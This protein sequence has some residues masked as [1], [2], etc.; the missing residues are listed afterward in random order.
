MPTFRYDC[1]LTRQQDSNEAPSFCIFHAPVGEILEW[2]DIKRLEEE[3]GAPQRR[4]SP[5]KVK[6]VTRYLATDV[7]NT[8]PTSVIL[9]LDVSAPAPILV[10]DRRTSYGALEFTHN[11]GEPRPGLVIDGQH[12]LLG[13][14]DF[15]PTFQ[16][17]V[18]A[19]FGANDMEKAF[20]FLVINNKASKVSMDHIR[21]LALHYQEDELQARLTTARLTLNPNLGF[22]GLV[23]SEEESPFRGMIDW[24]I[25]PE[26]NRVVVPAAIENAITY[27]QQQR[28]KEFESDDVLL[29]F[30]YTLWRKLRESWP[31]LWTANSHL[32]EKVG[33]LCMTQYLTDL[34][35][36]SYDLGKLDV[37]DP[38]AVGAVVSD[39]LGSSERHFW[40]KRWTSTSY[41]TKAGHEL[42]KRA[43]IQ[44]SR[45]V[46]MGL[47]WYEDVD[48]VDPG[49]DL[50]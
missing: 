25:T 5:A 14:N 48:L 29:E 6:A 46:R 47:A 15:D 34:L 16:V 28:V 36:N 26:P 17:N 50:V 4:M 27:I 20:Q 45:N 35:V 1:L 23:N 37:S 22:V 12:R 32:L 42:I 9:T 39:I 18:V 21:A 2:A 19:I 8:I 7:R 44:I 30:F 43:L 24:P 41:D 10:E 3:A 49:T 13:I 11:P 31:E 40:T 38:Q 33:I